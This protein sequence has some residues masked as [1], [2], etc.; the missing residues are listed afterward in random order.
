MKRYNTFSAIMYHN[1]HAVTAKVKYL[2]IQF[3]IHKQYPRFSVKLW[4]Q[5]AIYSEHG[6]TD[7]LHKTKSSQYGNNK[8]TR[9]I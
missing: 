8:Y 9:F 6:I 1:Q 3:T 5:G 7:Q 4:W 2:A